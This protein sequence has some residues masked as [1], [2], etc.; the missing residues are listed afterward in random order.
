MPTLTAPAIHL[1]PDDSGRRGTRRVTSYD[2]ANVAGVSQSA[3][4][5]CFKPGASVSK[6]TYQRVMQAARELDYIPNAAARSLCT[7]R[8]NLVA[9]I[10]WE[11][12]I[13]SHPGIVTELTQQFAR[14]GMRA[15]L[16]TLASEAD[17]DGTLAALWQHQVDGAIV[18]ARLGEAHIAEF[19]RRALPFLLFNRPAGHEVNAVACDH[20]AAARTL[21]AR[22]ASAGHK[23]FAL[24]SG[25]ADSSV[26]Q[27]RLRGVCERLAELGLPRPLVV[28]GNFDYA[29]GA[30]AMREIRAR[31]E[32]LPDVVVCT[33][34]MMAIGCIDTARTEF[35]LS[36]PCDLSVTGFDGSASSG[37]LSYNLT[38]MR[39]PIAEMA[40]AAAE[41]FAGLMAGG[42]AP[43]QRLFSPVVVDGTTARLGP[44]A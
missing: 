26:A 27:E 11:Q 37:W 30:R 3:V 44:A 39:L 23:R 4:S 12:A 36:V 5:R 19:T 34:D 6:A 14:R 20:Y 32:A 22:L 33:N 16:F 10:L 15:V 41:M 8:S 31:S 25:P 24:V 9:V 7:R 40:L 21:A 35:G 29:S 42:A 13:L 38:T 17:I 2:V 1:P 28:A 18:A 43:Q